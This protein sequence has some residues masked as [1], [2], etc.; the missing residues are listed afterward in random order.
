VLHRELKAFGSEGDMVTALATFPSAPVDTN[1]DTDGGRE[2]PL[3]LPRLV[4]GSGTGQLW[5]YDPE[6]GSVLHR[7]P[8]PRA[9]VVGLACVPV[10]ACV[11]AAY[12]SHIQTAKVWDRETGAVLADLGGH[13]GQVGPVAVWKEHW[14]GHD[15]IA[16]AGGDR[17]I[18]VWGGE[19]FTLLHTLQCGLTVMSV[20]AMQSAEG[21]HRLLVGLDHG[22]GLQVWEPEEGRLLHDGINRDCPVTDLHLLESAQ[23]R[24][25]LAMVSRAA[26]ETSGFPYPRPRPPCTCGTW[27]RPRLWHGPSLCG[28]RTTWAEPRAEPSGCPR[29]TCRSARR[30]LPLSDKAKPSSRAP[31]VVGRRVINPGVV[32]NCMWFD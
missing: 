30:A 17:A 29:R 27:G 12:G 20:L 14:G 13:G 9:T 31:W 6:A 2:P 24:Q 19:A 11:V 28:R 23:G 18:R 21:P 3:S 25:L 16:V 1:T 32:G 4:A 22:G 15:R 8:G 26:D 7:L 5:V 10:S